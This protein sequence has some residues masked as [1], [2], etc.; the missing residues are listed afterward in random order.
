MEWFE[1]LLR[2]SP[3]TPLQG[4]DPGQCKIYRP[5]QNVPSLVL[6]VPSPKIWLWCTLQWKHWGLSTFSTRPSIPRRRSGQWATA[7]SGW[8]PLLPPRA[9]RFLTAVKSSWRQIIL[10]HSS[11]TP[12]PP[13]LLQPNS[14]RLSYFGGS[15]ELY[16]RVVFGTAL[17]LK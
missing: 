8:P 17:K 14:T 1:F 4:G 13:P 12:P 9:R 16:H 2:F 10:G 3:C 11:G 6:H 7:R 5:S 15:S